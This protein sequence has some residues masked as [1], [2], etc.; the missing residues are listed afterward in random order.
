MIALPIGAGLALLLRPHR[1]APVHPAPGP[2]ATGSSSGT[3][4]PPRTT[5]SAARPRWAA[6]S[7]IFAVLPELWH[8][9][10]DHVAD[11]SAV[12]GPDSV[13][14]AAVVPDGGPGPRR[15]PR[16]LHQDTK[17]RSLGPATPGEAH[18]PGRS[19]ASSSPCWPCSSRMTRH[20]PGVHA[21]LLRPRPER[22]TSPSAA[23]CSGPSCSSSGSPDRHR[24][25]NGVNLTDG[26]D[27]LATGASSW[28]SAP[29]R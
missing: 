6:R 7:I 18:R 10:P 3:T 8:H 4:A 11:G 14:P 9:P 21:H 2:R 29:T 27:G 15:L 1:H 13:G 24:R 12:P 5:P 22:S 17:Q 26:L 28:S 25:H 19:S 16:R 23:P 20:H